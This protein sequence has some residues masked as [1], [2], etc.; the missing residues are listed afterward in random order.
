[1][2]SNIMGTQMKII[3]K[4]SPRNKKIKKGKAKLDESPEEKNLRYGN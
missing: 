4:E 2:V 1:M 3:E